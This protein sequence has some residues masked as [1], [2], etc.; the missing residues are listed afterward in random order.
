MDK[1]TLKNILINTG[2]IQDNNYLD[3]YINLC[4]NNIST[5]KEKYKTNAHHVIPVAYYRILN[6]VNVRQKAEALADNDKNNFKVNLYF[7]DHLLAHY[8][9]VLCSNNIQFTAAMTSGISFLT[10]H[11]KLNINDLNLS[12]EELLKYQKLY[13]EALFKKT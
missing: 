11:T 2:F 4:L 13:E 12:S 5:N 1:T 3:L 9:L 8:Y 10:G 7:K 6:K